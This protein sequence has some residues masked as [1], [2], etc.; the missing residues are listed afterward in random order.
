MSETLTIII[1]YIVV[2]HVHAIPKG[3]LLYE[4]D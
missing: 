3:I 1:L 4:N 2:K